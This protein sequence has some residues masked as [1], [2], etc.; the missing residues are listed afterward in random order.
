M[1]DGNR[2]KIVGKKYCGIVGGI[3]LW[4]LMIFLF[5]VG[6]VWYGYII[7]GIFVFRRDVFLMKL[8]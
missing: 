2:G 1:S 8:L 5:V 3:I 7:F 6:V 4:V